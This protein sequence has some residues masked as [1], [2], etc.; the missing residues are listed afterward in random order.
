[1]G[2]PELDTISNAI[3]KL[4]QSTSPRAQAVHKLTLSYQQT[5]HDA[6]PVTPEGA[7]SKTAGGYSVNDLNPATQARHPN[8]FGTSATKAEAEKHLRA[9]EY[10]KHG[11]K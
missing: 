3:S 11:G 8:G 6:K 9:I 7:I 5:P 2:H 4:R 10:F 1:M